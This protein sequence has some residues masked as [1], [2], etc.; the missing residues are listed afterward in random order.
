MTVLCEVYD[1]RGCGKVYAYAMRALKVVGGILLALV[2]LAAVA[3][4]LGAGIGLPWLDRIL[5]KE[6]R[7]EFALPEGSR[8]VIQRGS[9]QQTLA[10]FVPGFSVDS[11]AAS[12]DGLK[13]E[14]LHFEGEEI[15][16]DFSKLRATR[17]VKLERAA[18]GEI[19]FKVSDDAL[20]DFWRTEIEDAGLKDPSIE[21]DA[22]GVKVSAVVDLKLAQVKLAAKGVFEVDGSRR[23]RF[24]AREFEA[25]GF[26]F[27]LGP[28]KVALSKLTPIVKLNQ[29]KMEIRVDELSTSDGYLTVRG[30]GVPAGSGEAADTADET[31]TADD[32]AAAPSSKEHSPVI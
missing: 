26:N 30:N 8:V 3:A 15:Q 28:F 11:A 9:L 1:R 7:D 6:V 29:F 25:G 19:S 13:V 17:K 24:R 12:L 32:S 4:A 22:K 18:R 23:I 2:I 21:I 27:N 20:L 16:F 14:D 5:A 31:G 10:G